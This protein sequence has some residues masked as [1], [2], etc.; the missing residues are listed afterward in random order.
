[1]DWLTTSTILDGL[2]DFGNHAAWDRFIGRFRVPIERFARKMGLAETDAQDVAQETL[3]AFARKCRAGA[4]DRSKGKLRHWV[5]GIA[6][7]EILKARRKLAR[8]A[9][10]VGGNGENTSF[11]ND[12]P[13]KEEADQSWTDEWRRALVQQC[14]AEVRTRVE[15]FTYRAFEM[16][17]IERQS[18]A[19]VASQLGVS[20]NR[21][22]VAK[23]RVTRHMRRL[24]EEYDSVL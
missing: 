4:Y 15:P 16:V 13:D 20:T 14:L 3:L 10:Q 12:V 8:Q 1:M 11:W 22:F 7:R 21:V 23:H 19:E 17:V 6:Y 24:K 9:A 18:P 5:F 2:R